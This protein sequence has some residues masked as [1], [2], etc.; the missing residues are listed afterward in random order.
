[1]LEHI[2]LVQPPNQDEKATG[3]RQIVEKMGDH[4]SPALKKNMKFFGYV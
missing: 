2:G 1:V 3:P 4:S